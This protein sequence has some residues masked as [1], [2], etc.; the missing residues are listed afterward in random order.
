MYTMQICL[1]TMVYLNRIFGVRSDFIHVV[2]EDCIKKV[3]PE[4]FDT[5]MFFLICSQ[6]H[7]FIE[8]GKILR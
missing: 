6:Y 5:R 1:G 2:Y 3:I 4:E 8:F 7:L